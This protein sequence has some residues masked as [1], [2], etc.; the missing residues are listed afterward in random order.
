MDEELEE[1]LKLTAFIRSGDREGT[2]VH[3]EKG[4]KD[5]HLWSRSNENPR[6]SGR[7]PGQAV[8]TKKRC[9]AKNKIEFKVQNAIAIATVNATAT[10]FVSQ[11]LNLF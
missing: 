11:T 1:K 5:K 10:K 8:S 6:F 2:K 9:N 7:G 4:E 3:Q